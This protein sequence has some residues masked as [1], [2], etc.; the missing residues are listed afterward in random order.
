[1]RDVA[2]ASS[3]SGWSCIAAS[4]NW[5]PALP[6]VTVTLVGR[7]L[8]HTYCSAD[9]LTS[10]A[11][12][13]PRILITDLTLQDG[14]GTSRGRYDAARVAESVSQPFPE[15]SVVLNDQHSYRARV[16]AGA[17]R[18]HARISAWR[19]RRPWNPWGVPR[20]AGT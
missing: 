19:P 2:H 4:S 3:R 10:L 6:V 17:R 14:F 12:A 20:W 18:H 1:M 16:V 5:R 8:V 9:G 11:Q 15:G 13:P 7:S